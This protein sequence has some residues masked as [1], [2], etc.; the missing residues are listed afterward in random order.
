MKKLILGLSSLE[1]FL[2]A[3]EEKGQKGLDILR[4]KLMKITMFFLV[5]FGL[6]FVIEAEI[7]FF[8]LGLWAPFVINLFLYLASIVFLCLMNK[9]PYKIISTVAITVFLVWSL[10]VLRM[11]GFTGVGLYAVFV[12]PIFTAILLDANKGIIVI[13]I[14][15]FLMFCIWLT[16]RMGWLVPVTGILND[17]SSTKSWLVAIGIF[18]SWTM[19]ITICLKY[20]QSWLIRSLDKAVTQSNELS[21][22]NEKLS[23]E[24]SKRKKFEQELMASQEKLLQ[25]QKMESVGRL[26]GGIAHDFNNMLTGIIGFISLAKLNLEKDDPQSELLNEVDNAA[27]K[28]ADLTRQ[29]LTFSRKQ[30]M[31]FN[32]VDLNSLLK[33][34]V[35]LL[36][37]LIGEDIQLKLTLDNQLQLVKIDSGQIEQAI[38]NLAI[39]ARDAMP[40]GGNLTI[41]TK[42]ITPGMVSKESDQLDIS[43]NYAKITVSDTGTGI[44]ETIKS[45]LF[46]PF[47]TTK[48]EGQGTGLGL[49]TVFGIV[50]QHKGHIEFHS[51]KNEGTSFHLYLPITEQDKELIIHNKKNDDLPLGT[52]TILLVEDDA[53]IRKVTSKILR[54]LGYNVLIAENGNMAIDIFQ[55]KSKE[56]DLLL[57]DIIM[58]KM[59]GKE[60]S[61]HIR[62]T[63]PDIKILYMSGYEENVIS[64]HGILNEGLNFISKPFNSS[65]L[66]RKI[67]EVI[68]GK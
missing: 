25:A 67:R 62:Q 32:V 35:K 48:K 19:L 20:I 29:L 58:P 42:N 52:E 53:V 57:T 65:K 41:K 34:T 21:K 38:I 10:N 12:C 44:D 13:F 43:L 22:T 68:D 60:L 3:N 33:G 16:I 49:S 59:N 45:N 24:I 54:R 9:I 31:N 23:R 55:E 61:D 36:T 30:I 39:N 28:A 26:A 63:H 14:G 7:R 4:A 11:Y 66:S 51:V 46:E 2:S 6:P 15:T 5:V 8:K 50:K 1:N 18:F 27:N 47:F 56:I 40:N 17:S 37:R 64:K